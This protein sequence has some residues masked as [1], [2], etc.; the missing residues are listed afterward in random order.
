MEHGDREETS[1]ILLVTIIYNNHIPIR[2][3]WS[4]DK[5]KTLILFSMD[6]SYV[7]WMRENPKNKTTDDQNQ[8]NHMNDIFSWWLVHTELLFVSIEAG[9]IQRQLICSCRFHGE[10]DNR[11]RWKVDQELVRSSS[12]TWRSLHNLFTDEHK[13]RPALTLCKWN[14]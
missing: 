9:F 1:L 14:F 2:L 5:I 11:R 4:E 6:S 3:A 12:S 10:R 13:N 8:G 7:T